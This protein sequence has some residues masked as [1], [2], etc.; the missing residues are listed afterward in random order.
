MWPK[1]LIS[2]IS[3]SSPSSEL[4]S[5]LHSC[6][7]Q[8]EKMEFSVACR[9]LR[10]LGR[11]RVLFYSSPTLL[12]SQE[13]H[14]FKRYQKAKSWA[15]CPPT[16][17]RAPAT[18]SQAEKEESRVSGMLAAEETWASTR[19]PLSNEKPFK[20]QKTTKFIF[21]A[22]KIQKQ[23]GIEFLIA[24]E[25]SRAASVTHDAVFQAGGHCRRAQ[26]H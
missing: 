8:W 6:W 2:F 22:L 4:L 16:T 9:Y 10:V 11:R 24:A 20:V 12:P 17:V 3:F 19:T 14:T 15:V 18:R 13:E 5:S 21:L 26:L 23:D 7:F 1:L 25:G